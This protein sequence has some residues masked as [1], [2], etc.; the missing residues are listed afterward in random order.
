LHLQSLSKTLDDGI[1]LP[2]IFGEVSGMF[3]EDSDP[4]DVEIVLL[5]VVVGE[6]LNETILV[7]DDLIYEVACFV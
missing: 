1:L 7:L 4:L 3:F 5:D 6:F 2:Q